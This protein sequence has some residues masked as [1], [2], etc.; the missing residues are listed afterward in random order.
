MIAQVE[1][2]RSLLARVHDL[3]S[4]AAVLEWDQETYLPEAG[5]PARGE[6]LSVGLVGNCAE[7]LPELGVTAPFWFA[8]IGSAIFVVLIWRQLAHVSHAD[9]A[10]A[11]SAV[12]LDEPPGDIPPAR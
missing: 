8:F 6:A 12:I 3:N 4:A 1:Y 9:E 2:L 11:P 7:V 10:E 5:Q